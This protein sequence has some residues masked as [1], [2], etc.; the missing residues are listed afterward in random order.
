VK[1][2]FMSHKKDLARIQILRK[3]ALYLWL[4]LFPT[5]WCTMGS[6]ARWRNATSLK[7]WILKKPL[8]ILKNSDDYNTLSYFAQSDWLAA[9]SQVQG[10]DR[11]TLTHYL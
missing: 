4:G 5:F 1:K 11:L 9:D 2:F 10:D 6:L 7:N 8:R 3:A